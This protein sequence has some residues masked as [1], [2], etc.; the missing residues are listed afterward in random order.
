MQ[1]ITT[2]RL[3]ATLPATLTTPATPDA[4][5][6]G[7]VRN[8][9]ID[10][11]DARERRGARPQASRRRNIS[12]RSAVRAVLLGA[13]ALSAGA[14]PGA[15]HGA[16]A[17]FVA[18]Q[19]R[20]TDGSR[21]PAAGPGAAPLDRWAPPHIPKAQA[22]T[23]WREALPPVIRDQGLGPGTPRGRLSFLGVGGRSIAL[24]ATLPEQ[25]APLGVLKLIRG[26]DGEVAHPEI[27]DAVATAL[28]DHAAGAA[29]Q[30]RS[31]KDFIDGFGPIVPMTVSLGIPALLQERGRGVPFKEL[32]ADRRATAEAHVAAVVAAA[33]A[34][35]P[36]ILFSRSLGNF[37][38]DPDTGRVS[39]WFDVVADS[40]RSYR[41]R[42][43]DP[44]EVQLATRKAPRFEV[45][46]EFLGRGASGEVLL[47]REGE[48]GCKVALKRV[49]KLVEAVRE[50][51]HLMRSAP[52]AGEHVQR[53]LDLRVCWE[54]RP[55]AE[56]ATA[57]AGRPVAGYE[58]TQPRAPKDA[59]MIVRDVARGL[60][61]MHRGG[62]LHMDVHPGNVLV[63]DDG[64]ITLIDLGNVLEMNRSGRAHRERSNPAVQPFRAPEMM[65]PGGQEMDARTDVFAATALLYHL[66][67]GRPPFALDGHWQG[68][69]R[70]AVLR[71][72]AQGP[73]LDRVPRALHALLRDG[74]HRDREQ[75]PRNAE[76]LV[77]RL[78]ACLADASL[79]G[80][81]AQPAAD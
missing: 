52:Y 68:D 70:E 71:A 10:L 28:A 54:D 63:A 24:E 3:G 19:P 43:L 73:R 62:L 75:R 6:D 72:I 16:E 18:V 33:T 42:G 2:R 57:Y 41:Q 5:A 9:D 53:L 77:A 12:L 37:L 80:G 67:V 27:T 8:R 26:R 20:R 35:F 64:K 56:I 48:T 38:F 13:L 29:M 23:R 32:D 49:G 58:W 65:T 7:K 66:I 34:H 40:A 39:A 1:W 46:P 45:G 59:L 78:E 55:I 15:V 17:G 30:L 74:L 25:M 51:E 21:C 4:P 79:A 61:G 60:A 22:S 31:C 14:A 47:A 81:D 44:L 69:R 11:R 50:A 36:D 76:A